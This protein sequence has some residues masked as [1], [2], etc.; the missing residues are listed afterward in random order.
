MGDKF[1]K[2]VKKELAARSGHRCASPTCRRP[3]HGP[4]I[5]G[6]GYI[7]VG[8]A[9]HIT[10]ASPSGPR[11]DSSLSPAERSS[12]SNGIWLCRTCEALVDSDPT[13]YTEELLRRWKS[14]AEARAHSA[15]S[16]TGSESG[17]PEPLF[18][19]IQFNDHPPLHRLAQ[20]IAARGIG[21]TWVPAERVGSK[22]SLGYVEQLYEGHAVHTRVDGV[23]NVWM[24]K[25]L[26]DP[27]P[28]DLSSHFEFVEDDRTGDFVRFHFYCYYQ[29]GT[30]P[31]GPKRKFHHEWAISGTELELSSDSHLLVQ[32][33][34]EEES[35]RFVSEIEDSLNAAGSRLVFSE[36][37]L[38]LVPV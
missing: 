35:A 19:D 27:V 29:E 3:T 25:P 18:V 37:G 6:D 23:E 2:G 26:S 31:S 12:P 28:D 11:Y 17:Q 34:R 1:D 4:R 33:R 9:A 24:T 38:C 30:A 5:G 13:H 36:E 15:L 14:E 7:N 10:A 21:S 8:V 22:R 16:A 32:R 20:Q